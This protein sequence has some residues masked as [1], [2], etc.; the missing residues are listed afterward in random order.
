MILSS[1]QLRRIKNQFEVLAKC[2]VQINT[3]ISPGCIYAW[4]D[5]LSM[6]RIAEKLRGGSNFSYGY[7]KP[8]G[9]FFVC[10]EF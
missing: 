1:E 10:L 2:A 7:S 3:T 5:E 6:Y 8:R 9:T 4:V